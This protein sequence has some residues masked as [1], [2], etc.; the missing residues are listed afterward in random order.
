MF[1][2]ICLINNEF[3]KHY[4]I[5]TNFLLSDK[6]SDDVFRWLYQ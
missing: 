5:Q 2:D 6:I 3:Y 4:K 1:S